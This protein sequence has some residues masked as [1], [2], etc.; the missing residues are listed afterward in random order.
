MANTIARNIVTIVEKTL[1][2]ADTATFAAPP[3]PVI[4][5]LTALV[6]ADFQSKSAPGAVRFIS[7]SSIPSWNFSSSQA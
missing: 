5:T 7:L 3:T 1:L 2:T 6:I 4:T